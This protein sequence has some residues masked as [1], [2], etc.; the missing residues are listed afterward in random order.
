MGYKPRQ[1]IPKNSVEMLIGISTD[2]AVRMKPSRYPFI[3]NKYPL[4]FDLHFSR[5]DCLR[6]M[7]RNGYALP[8]KSSC[9][10]CPFHNDATWRDMKL[11]DPIEFAKAVE[12]DAAIR[13]DKRGKVKEKLYIHKSMKPLGEVDF[14]NLEDKGQQNLFGQECEGMCGV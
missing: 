10:F 2:E 4:I 13:E 12:F 8:S 11:N 5:N 6:W 1:R 14:R 9:V 7:E 3:E